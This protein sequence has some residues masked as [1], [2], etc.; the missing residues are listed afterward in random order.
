MNYADQKII[1]CSEEESFRNLLSRLPQEQFAERTVEKVNIEG[2]L[3]FS[4]TI[5][6]A[7]R[8]NFVIKLA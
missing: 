5:L 8:V 7:I 6:T 3:T 2:H 4:F 1:S